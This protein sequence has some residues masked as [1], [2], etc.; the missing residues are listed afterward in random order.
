[1]NKVVFWCFTPYH[2]KVS[3]YLSRTRYQSYEKYIIISSF[4]GISKENLIE[5]VEKELYIDI[6]YIRLEYSIKTI[7]KNPIKYIKLSRS[8]LNEFIEY[9][10]FIIPDDIAIFTDDLIPYQIYLDKIKNKHINIT[11]I[12]EGVGIYLN[13]Y[14]FSFKFKIRFNIKKLVFNYFKA[15]LY[16][17]GKGGYENTIIA[18]RIDLLDS[19]AQE[20]IYLNKDEF[21]LLNYNKVKK[22]VI[23]NTKN[24]IL[25]SPAGTIY[26]KKIMLNMFDNIFKYYH[27]KG[28][29]LYVKLHPAEKYFC[30]IEKLI[31]KYNDRVYLIRE[32]NITSEDLV[33]SGKFDAIISDFSS[34]L[35]NAWYINEE[36]KL[37]SYKNVLKDFYK[38]NLGCEY[39]IL[40]EF[41]KEKKIVEFNVKV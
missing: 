22:K 5:F 16:I 17:H 19:K 38:V 2:I 40:D 24:N 31:E 30:E 8:Q 21:K 18:R 26:N 41:I 1:M 10:D 33:L 20:R 37:I 23:I 34:T 32:K 25:L 3:N 15:R 36:I 6:K 27:S 11:L 29:N 14:N 9:N 12:E 13:K 39:S 28:S 35:I 4:T 7:L